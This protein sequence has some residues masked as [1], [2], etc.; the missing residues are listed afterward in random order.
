MKLKAPRLTPLQPD[1]WDA[2]QADLMQRFADQAPLNVFTT[3]LRHPDLFR[4]WLP[5]AN[6]VLG[7]SSLIARDRELLILRTAWNAQSEYEWGQHALIAAGEGMSAADLAAAKR[8]PDAPGI[9]AREGLLLRAADELMADAFLTDVTWA[10]LSEHYDARQLM[11]VVFTVGQYNMLAM[12]LNAFG[13]QR[14]AG[15][16]G[17]DD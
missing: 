11:D 2:D 3:L 8:G 4:R 1:E 5:F 17:F 13:V 7:K 15:V 6:H 10:G 16:P 9:D 12:A 14:D